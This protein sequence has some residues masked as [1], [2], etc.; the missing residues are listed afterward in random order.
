MGVIDMKI[1]T[2]DYHNT[3]RQV[4]IDTEEVSQ[5]VTSKDND[6]LY[7]FFKDIDREPIEVC[8]GLTY[9]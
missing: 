6:R 8:Q 1:L 9:L 3:Y 5:I 2:T 4:E 7:V